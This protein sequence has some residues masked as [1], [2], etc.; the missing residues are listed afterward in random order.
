MSPLNKNDSTI[1]PA[2]SLDGKF[3]LTKSEQVLVME[4][5]VKHQEVRS[6]SEPTLSKAYEPNV[7]PDNKDDQQTVCTLNR[8]AEKNGKYA[9]HLSSSPLE[10]HLKH[11]ESALLVNNEIEELKDVGIENPYT[12]ALISKVDNDTEAQSCSFSND[13]DEIDCKKTVADE[14][15]ADEV[16]ADEVV[17]DE[18]VADEVV[19]ESTPIPISDNTSP[20]YDVTDSNITKDSDELSLNTTDLL[21]LSSSGGTARL[22]VK[23]FVESMIDKKSEKHKEDN[24][25]DMNQV[26][27]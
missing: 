3:R 8:Q 9:E 1:I 20:P 6:S 26:I 21:H 18:V 25:P 2:H 17:A 12:F 14:V 4:E 11:F 13:Q 7:L 22:K 24:L 5:S 19:A 27:V 15:V 16:V 10:F 23:E